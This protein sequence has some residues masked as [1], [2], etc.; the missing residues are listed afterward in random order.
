M[1]NAGPVPCFPSLPTRL[2]PSRSAATAPCPPRHLPTGQGHDWDST[3]AGFGCTVG[4]APVV[5]VGAAVLGSLSPELAHARHGHT[6]KVPAGLGG[7]GAPESCSQGAVQI[8]AGSRGCPLGFLAGEMFILL[9]KYL[10]KLP[11]FL[12]AG[13]A[14]IGP[15]RP[16]PA[17]LSSSG[18]ESCY[19]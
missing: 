13:E 18:T 16:L 10:C 9:A 14:A 5:L 17:P 7:H 2:P 3:G 12:A 11:D 19:L 1:N 4:A 6:D 8:A 15:A